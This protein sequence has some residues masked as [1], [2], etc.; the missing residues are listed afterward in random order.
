MKIDS[1]AIN[2]YA[3]F[4][5]EFENKADARMRDILTMA[6]LSKNPMTIRANANPGTFDSIELYVGY[7]YVSYCAYF[8]DDTCYHIPEDVWNNPTQENV[9]DWRNNLLTQ[10]KREKKAAEE[11]KQAILEQKDRELYERLRAKY[12]G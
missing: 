12:D 4:R 8:D 5:E 10:E 9:T 7:V 2:D 3:E 11:E 6:W 1:T